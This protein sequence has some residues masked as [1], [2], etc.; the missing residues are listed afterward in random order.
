MCRRT[1][2]HIAHLRC[3]SPLGEKKNTWHLSSRVQFSLIG[4]PLFIKMSINRICSACFCTVACS[5]CFWTRNSSII[6]RD[7]LK[8]QVH[9]CWESSWRGPVQTHPRSV[10]K[11]GT[12]RLLHCSKWS[13][14]LLR[15]I[16]DW[17]QRVHWTWIRLSWFSKAS[18]TIG[19]KLEQKTSRRHTGHDVF[20]ASQVPI[21]FWQNV[22]PQI[23]VVTG[24]WNGW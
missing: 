7:A 11:H 9:S 18:V 3:W 19:A 10:A 8:E 16:G 24:D 15:W 12:V 2:K 6:N 21:H 22:W 5:C 1:L 17:W 4:L 20:V 13:L 23:F 14:K